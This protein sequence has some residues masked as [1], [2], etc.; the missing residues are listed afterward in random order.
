MPKSLTKSDLS[1]IAFTTASSMI[2]MRSSRPSGSKPHDSTA[3]RE[4]NP[5]YGHYNG[6]TAPRNST[7]TR[8]IASLGEDRAA[9]RSTAESGHRFAASAQATT[10]WSRFQRLNRRDN[11]MG[12]IAAFLYGLAAY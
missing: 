10:P 9:A 5:H 12:R 4:Q 7:S 11:I 2:L 6:L 1:S 3:K 8:E